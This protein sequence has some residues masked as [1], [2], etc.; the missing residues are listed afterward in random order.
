MINFIKKYYTKFFDK[1]NYLNLKASHKIDETVK[2][3]K[4]TEKVLIIFINQ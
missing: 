2:I 3:F 4:N 1:K